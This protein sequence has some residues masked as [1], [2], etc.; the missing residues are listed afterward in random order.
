MLSKP[1]QDELQ[2]QRHIESFHEN[3]FLN[4]LLDMMDDFIYRVVCALE[5]QGDS[6]FPWRFSKILD[7]QQ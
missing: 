4:Q 6:E 3:E 2:L 1:L 7:L 5:I